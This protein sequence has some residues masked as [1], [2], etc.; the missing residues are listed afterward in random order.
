MA[1]TK[2]SALATG[3][4]VDLTALNEYNSTNF[5]EY[6]KLEAPGHKP[7]ASENLRRTFGASSSEPQATSRKRQAPSEAR[8][9]QQASSSEQQAS[10]SEPQ[11]TS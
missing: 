10:S 5:V 7:Q 1:N 6:K 8:N 4:T 9:K 2:R 11:A 3:F